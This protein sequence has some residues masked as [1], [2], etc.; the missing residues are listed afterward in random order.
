MYSELLS[1]AAGGGMV[2]THAPHAWRCWWRPSASRQRLTIRRRRRR[3]RGL[4]DRIA[5]AAAANPAA[6]PPPPCPPGVTVGP[7]PGRGRALIAARDFRAGETILAERPLVAVPMPGSKSLACARCL[8][9]LGSEQLHMDVAA[10]RVGIDEASKEVAGCTCVGCGV[11]YCSDACRRADLSR[12][13][14]LLCEGGP[15]AV[16]W[17][18]FKRHAREEAELPELELAASL[19]A[20]LLCRAAQAHQPI[21]VRDGGSA[22]A[23]AL[24]LVQEPIGDVLRRDAAGAAAAEQTLRDVARSCALLRAALL[25]ACGAAGVASRDVRRLATMRGPN[26]FGNLVGLVMLNQVA[27][28]VS[29][30]A[31]RRVERLGQTMGA[32]AVDATGGGVRRG[33]GAA[34]EASHAVLS[35]LERLL[36]L[37]EEARALREAEAAAEATDEATNEAAEEAA[38]EVSS[39]ASDADG[40]GG[41]GDGRMGVGSLVD[42]AGEL[43]PPLDAT[44]LAWFV[45]LMNHSC[46]P[47]AVVSYGGDD[48]GGGGSGEQQQQP[49]PAVVGDAG[50][51]RS[52]AVGSAAAAA[53]AGLV[54]GG[55]ATARIVA[56][57]DISAGEEI[58]HPYVDRAEPRRLRRES[59][60][61]YGIECR[62]PRCGPR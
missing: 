25:R 7:L 11:L 12:G 58:V 52:G 28:T 44:G 48:G 41:G 40:G 30:P 15:A 22:G 1:E 19:L 62:C 49:P 37:A 20:V 17:R 26:S 42:L 5:L 21:R 39:E 57:T 6:T 2:A 8:A 53:T 33:R 38:D 32:P 55:A 35:E 50:R 23:V 59:L 29:S 31:Q 43:F 61:I 46:A 13:H 9:F 14:R 54:R 10:G 24:G 45:C 16:A 34:S 3:H 47:N 27:V 18:R 60:A 4:H 51:R 36:P 56:L